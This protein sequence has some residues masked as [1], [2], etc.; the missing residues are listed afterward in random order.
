MN[1]TTNLEAPGKD[2]MTKPT[3]Y[4]VDDDPAIVDSLRFLLDQNGYPVQTFSSG[5]DLFRSIT[6]ETLG[7]LLLDVRIPGLD[8]LRVLEIL[9][10]QGYHL[11][12]I[13]VTGHGDIPMTV[14]AIKGGAVEFI[15]KP[16][17]PET[18]VQAIEEAARSVSELHPGE[19]QPLPEIERFAPLNRRERVILNGIVRGL[20]NK[21][22]AE[23]LDVSLRT[24]QFGR[25]RMF[26][27]I[28][29]EDRGELMDWIVS[30]QIDLKYFQQGQTP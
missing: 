15:E 5:E 19:E 16:F 12:V 17:Y 27:K 2:C 3:I 20:S 23:L 22:I 10:D 14:R 1:T 4:V 25:S 30:N 18:L 7:V 6:P 29:F 24:I 28:G 8:G 21:E 13:M 26:Q 9:R 11:K